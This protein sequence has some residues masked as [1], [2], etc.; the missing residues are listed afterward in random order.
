M[1]KY[2][3]L[4]LLS[5]ILFAGCSS[6][7]EEPASPAELKVELAASTET[8][9]Q[10]GIGK[11]QVLQEE[12]E[13]VLFIGR[14]NAG[15]ELAQIQV[16]SLSDTGARVVLLQPEK[17]ETEVDSNGAFTG[18]LTPSARSLLQALYKDT[19]TAKDTK[20]IKESSEDSIGVAQQ[21]LSIGYEGHISYWGGWFGYRANF[22]VGGWCPNGG[23]RSW[24]ES[25]SDNGSSCAVN[26]WASSQVNDCTINLHLGIGAFASDVCHWY[27]YQNP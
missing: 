20:T 17:A 12:S 24:A 7:P 27:V 11:W 10:H 1:R 25:Y 8:L 23:V 14:D 3:G 15:R 26:R 9:G 19:A 2:S 6:A 5:G 16:H 18:E 13:T 22:N 21:A 4:A